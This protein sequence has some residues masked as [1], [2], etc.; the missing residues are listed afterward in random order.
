M[1]MQNDD[2][3]RKQNAGVT[4]RKTI[5]T[6]LRLLRDAK[7]IKG[8]DGE[9]TSVM[10]SPHFGYEGKDQRQFR[11]DYTYTLENGTKIMIH[12]ETSYDNGRFKAKEWDSFH[13]KKNEKEIKKSY[14]LYPDNLDEQNSHNFSVIKRKLRNKE[15]ATSIDGIYN[16][17]EF[18]HLIEDEVLG[19]ELNGSKAAKKG[20]IFELILVCVLTLP[21]NFQLWKNSDSSVVGWKYDLFKDIMDYLKINPADVVSVSATRNIPSLPDYIYSD[22]TIKQGGKPK[23]DVIL[24]VTFADGKEK[25][26]TFSCKNTSKNTVHANQ[27][28]ARYAVDLLDLKPAD[29]FEKLLEQYRI[30][31]GPNNFRK[32][33]LREYERL[34]QLFVPYVDEF[35]RW[36][37]CGDARDGATREQI[38]DYIVTCHTNKNG[39]ELY[40][41]IDIDTYIK[42]MRIKLKKKTFGTIFSWTVTKKDRDGKNDIRVKAKV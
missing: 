25:Q 39:S 19:I 1:L 30:D 23:T 21:Q 16:Q 3:S 14:V 12:T 35:E 29:E 27:F 28:S 34:E 32:K 31:G 26:Y 22:G 2:Q 11:C 40:S 20:I 7:V 37:L 17:T 10:N 9:N 15:V 13:I 6:I 38:A 5:E 8:F 4:L 41:I 24:L 42:N 18:L 36:C 33:H